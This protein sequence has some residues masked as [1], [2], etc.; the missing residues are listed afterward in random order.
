M[1]RMKACVRMG[2]AQTER[3]QKLGPHKC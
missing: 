1:K 2:G 3:W